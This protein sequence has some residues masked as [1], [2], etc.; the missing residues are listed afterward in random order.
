M[1]D[2]SHAL[3][4]AAEAVEQADAEVKV[5][6]E[7]LLYL[8]S[9]IPEAGSQLEV[10]LKEYRD[11]RSRPIRRE[12]YQ[13]IVSLLQK[14]FLSAADPSNPLRRRMLDELMGAV[15]RREISERRYSEAIA[16]YQRF[17][18]SFRGKLALT[19]SGGSK[20]F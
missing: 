6:E 17:V 16:D 11:A 3:S 19:V 2:A 9:S 8:S 15:N 1:W 10:L 20:D 12:A 13:K 7:R 5:Q 14:V 4:A 18:G